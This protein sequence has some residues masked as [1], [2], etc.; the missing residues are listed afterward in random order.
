MDYFC[1]K[2]S[3]VQSAKIGEKTSIW[4]FVVILA[5]AVIGKNCNINTFVFIEND[6]VVGDNV[7]IKSGVQVWDGVVLEDNV[8]VFGNGSVNHW[9]HSVQQNDIMSLSECQVGS[10]NEKP[11]FCPI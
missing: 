5:G 11:T 1:H 4:Q 2:L 10:V 3:D 9:R 7:T 6:V 8:F